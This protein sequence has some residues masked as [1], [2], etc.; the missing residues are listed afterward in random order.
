MMWIK[1]F[2][3]G[4]FCL[5]LTQSC[6]AP[7]AITSE[8][9]SPCQWYIRGTMVNEKCFPYVAS[10]FKDSL[11][12]SSVMI[13]NRWGELQFQSDGFEEHWICQGDK[14]EIPSIAYDH[15]SLGRDTINGSLTVDCNY[16]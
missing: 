5:V 15:L 14:K 6:K 4:C 3:L 11:T 12:S 13:Y 16:D 2:I 1:C 7:Q 9:S 10:S 8:A